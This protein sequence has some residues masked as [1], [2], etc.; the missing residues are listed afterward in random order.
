MSYHITA[1]QAA[2]L[3]AYTAK[4]ANL[5][6]AADKA[7]RTRKELFSVRD[8]ETVNERTKRKS[9]ATDLAWA[10]KI[11]LQAMKL[12]AK[13]VSITPLAELHKIPRQQLIGYM[14]RYYGYKPV[15]SCGQKRKEFTPEQTAWAVN[16]RKAGK[17][18]REIAESFGVAISTLR[19]NMVLPDEPARR[20]AHK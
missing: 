10:R 1:E 8:A 7:E 16:Q 6:D 14:K 11:G 20:S 5:L 17:T 2:S 9:A 19:H 18:L 4:I 13:G 15:S 12:T 3:N